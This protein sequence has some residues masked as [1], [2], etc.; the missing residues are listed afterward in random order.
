MKMKDCPHCGQR[1]RHSNGNYC[2]H[3]GKELSE[4]NVISYKGYDIE[5]VSN[6][7]ECFQLDTEKSYITVSKEDGTVDAICRKADTFNGNVFALEKAKLI[8]DYWTQ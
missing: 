2:S 1:I 5:V 8:I 7:N 4:Y 3:C 6:R